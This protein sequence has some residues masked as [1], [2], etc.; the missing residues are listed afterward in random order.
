M[1][2]NFLGLKKTPD[3]R[4]IFVKDLEL[5]E[6]RS[7]FLVTSQRK[8]LWNVQI[9]LIKEFAR[10]CK[11]HNIRWFADGGTLLG[12]VRH[13]GFIPWD[14]DVDI[15][16]LRPDY[17]KFVEIAA[18]EFKYPYFLDNWF[19][20]QRENEIGPNTP[21]D[22]TLQLVTKEVDKKYSLHY[23]YIPFLKLRDLRTTM[24]EIPEATTTHQCI[25]IDICPLDA[26]MPFS[27]EEYKTKFLSSLVFLDATVHYE[28]AKELLKSGNVPVVSKSELEL[29]LSL[30]YKQRAMIFDKLATKNYDHSETV[31][32]FWDLI[33]RGR[34]LCYKKSFFEQTINLPFESIELPVPVGWNDILT[35]LYG[36]WQ[37]LVIYKNHSQEYSTNIPYSEYIKNIW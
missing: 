19:N 8:K 17:N 23:P 1:G 22:T 25:W 12:A 21:R 15:S 2:I 31:G 7:G 26:V 27:E 13:K 36:D 11:K 37:K 3:N 4:E 35:V 14:D 18:D 30:P 10:V 32:M 24:I 5:D 6:I 20:Y 34:F 28:A 9:G 33:V 29:F 16:M